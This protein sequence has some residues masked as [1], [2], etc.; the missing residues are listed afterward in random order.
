[1]RSRRAS[2]ADR[3][4]RRRHPRLRRRGIHEDSGR[5][6][7][8]ILLDVG[9]GRLG[10]GVRRWRR[11]PDVGVDRLG[12][13]SFYLRVPRRP[14]RRHRRSV[15]RGAGFLLHRGCVHSGFATVGVPR[16]RGGGDKI[17]RARRRPP[18]ATSHE[19]VTTKARQSE[20]IASPARGLR[21]L[22]VAP[23][24]AAR[25]QPITA[26]VDV[27][28]RRRRTERSSSPRRCPTRHGRAGD[29]S[30][31]RRRRRGGPA[32]PRRSPPR[33]AAAAGASTGP[34]FLGAREAGWRQRVVS[35]SLRF[36][37]EVSGEQIRHSGIA[38]GL[39][40]E[41]GD[42]SAMM[43]LM[44]EELRQRATRAASRTGRPRGRNEKGATRA[45]R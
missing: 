17:V 41:R 20:R 19:S 45:W 12:V 36:V 13:R 7:P 24:P 43:R 29:E 5:R 30:R 21:L 15:C 44:V 22:T 10:R 1:M 23:G 2:S 11:W 14:G 27:P 35:A 32:D 18:R 25:G 26:P 6:P 31:N 28:W 34:R 40:E 8:P 37:A 4:S 9:G 33:V 38:P 3:R 42:L 16:I 39:H